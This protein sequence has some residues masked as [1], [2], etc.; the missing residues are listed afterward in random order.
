ME[1]PYFVR[2]VRVAKAPRKAF[3]ERQLGTGHSRTQ[4]ALYDRYMGPLLFEPYAKLVAERCAVLQPDCILETAVG[5]GIVTRE[6]HRAAP[7]VR[8]VA[9]DV[10]PAIC[11]MDEILPESRW[12]F[13]NMAS[14]GVNN[15]GAM[16]P[17]AGFRVIQLPRGCSS[18]PRRRATVPV[19]DVGLP[20]QE[21]VGN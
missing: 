9:T 7:R 13:P 2:G 4:L 19:Y 16:F 20:V 5:G 1:V 8:V 6:V 18:G 21:Q 12:S 11:R 10:N 17:H 3:E 14:T 15:A